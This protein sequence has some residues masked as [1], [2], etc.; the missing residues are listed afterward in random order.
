M[1]DGAEC[2]GHGSHS[3]IAHFSSLKSVDLPPK[4]Q[5]LELPRARTPAMRLVLPTSRHREYK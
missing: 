4:N 1:H 2:T 5:K 3:N